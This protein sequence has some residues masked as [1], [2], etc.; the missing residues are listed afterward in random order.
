MIEFQVKID[1]EQIRQLERLADKGVFRALSH[2]AASIRSTAMRL[3]QKSKR[4]DPSLPGEPVHTR[5]GL[6]KR[7]DAIL[8]DASD[9]EDEAIIGFAG[10]ALGESMHVHEF[11]GRYKGVDYP[12]RPTMWPALEVNVTRFADEFRG[13]IGE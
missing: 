5:R 3:I 9:R 10:H 12:A 4:H 13:T 7:A 2:A 1:Q 8:F 6:A 11:G